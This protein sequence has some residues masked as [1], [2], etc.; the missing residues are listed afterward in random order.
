MANDTFLKSSVEP[1]AYKVVITHAYEISGW[2]IISTLIHSRAPHL[3]GMNGDFQSDLATLAFNNGEQLEKFPY[4][5]YHTSTG[6]YPIWR[7][8]ISYNNYLPLHKGIVKER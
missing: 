8:C 5:N 3:G 6:K 2:K 7:N 1:Q 4:H